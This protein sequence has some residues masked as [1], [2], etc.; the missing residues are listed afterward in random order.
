MCF[1]CCGYY[2]EIRYIHPF[3]FLIKIVILSVGVGVSGSLRGGHYVYRKVWSVW[4]NTLCFV[5]FWLYQDLLN[6]DMK[7]KLVELD[8]YYVSLYHFVIILPPTAVKLQFAVVSIYSQ[9]KPLVVNI[10]FGSA[11]WCIST[12]SCWIIYIYRFIIDRSNMD[13]RVRACLY[14]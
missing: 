3:K 6:L 11:K 2:M 8:L 4:Y 12:S 9:H 1:E 10:L 14:H 7:G 5:I 13:N